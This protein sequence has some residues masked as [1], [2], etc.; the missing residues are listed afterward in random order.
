[1][2]NVTMPDGHNRV[3]PYLIVADAVGFLGFVEQV[4]G[5]E[6]RYKELRD[7][8]AI[9]H[10]E[11]RIGESVLMFAQSTDEFQPQTAGMFIYVD[12][13]DA[14]FR[15]ALD[16]GAREIMAPADQEYGRSGGVQDP[17]GNTW[18]ITSV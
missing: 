8:G 5:A 2:G 15:K 11:V 14:V 17:F 18:W 16:A 3:M 10:A 4:F 9:R 12:D 1:M 7:D 13:A 6:E